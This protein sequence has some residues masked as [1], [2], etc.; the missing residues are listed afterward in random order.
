MTYAEEYSYQDALNKYYKLNLSQPTTEN[1]GRIQ[2]LNKKGAMAPQLDEITDEFIKFSENHTV[3]EIGGAYGKIMIE[4]LKRS[5][6]VIYHLNDLDE[7]H[8]FIAAHNFETAKLDQSTSNQVKFI[9]GDIT[10]KLTTQ[11]K[12]DSILIARVLH[13]FSPNQ[14]EQVIANIYNLLK[15]KGKV[16]II[17]MTHYVK[18]YES[19]I[20]EYEK[21]LLNKEPFPGYVEPLKNWGNTEVTNSNQ[22]ASMTDEPFMFLDEEVLST[23]FKKHHFKIIKCKKVELTYQ[24]K[25][26]SLD[27]RENVVIVAEKL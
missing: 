3:L 9:S 7:R 5:P 27:G 18:R 2:T 20:P 16:Y 19:F 17:A 24:S 26:W 8:L 6:K 23:S 10:K 4:T 13:F 1:D 14:L 25:S 21:R 22:I 11:T 12:Y 15:P